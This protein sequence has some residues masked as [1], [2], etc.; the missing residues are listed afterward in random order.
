MTDHE[1]GAITGTIMTGTTPPGTPAVGTDPSGIMP[2]IGPGSVPDFTGVLDIERT[3]DPYWVYLLHLKSA[4]SRRTMRG[5]LD[6]IAAM[7]AGADNADGND[8]LDGA[9]RPWGAL[10]YEH[11]MTIRAAMGARGWSPSHVNKHL[12]ALKGV[13][14]QAWLLGHMSA[15]DYLR[16]KEIGGDNGSRLPPGRTIHPDEHAAIQAACAGDD[17]VDVRD[18]AIVEVLRSTGLRRHELAKAKVEDY[19]AGER[20]LRVIGKGDKEREVFLYPS[21][22][23]ALARWINL[24]NLRTGPLIR[25]IDRHGNIK[26]TGISPAAISDRVEQRRRR[27]GVA[28][29]ATHDHRRTLA[30][31]MFDSGADVSQ[32]Q[33]ILGHSRAD[34]TL[35]YDRRPRRQLRTLIDRLDPEKPSHDHGGSE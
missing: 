20:C 2:A 35:L 17:P 27:A 16:I 7:L 15:E 3:R 9:G 4:E 18:A 5:C 14:K 1:P 32:V 13:L 25:R 21:A 28:P 6:R 22:A 33:R 19:D 31:D 24:A 12:S 30:G 29:M 34:T 23:D 8:R 10:R 26:D 11:A